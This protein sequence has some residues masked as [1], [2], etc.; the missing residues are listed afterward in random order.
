[1]KILITGADGMLGESLLTQLKEKGHRLFAFS[2]TRKTKELTPLEITNHAQV[3]HIITTIKPDSIVH[4]AALTNVDYCEQH[5]GKAYK[6]NFEATKHIVTVCKK[7]NIPLYFLSTGAVFSGEKKNPYVEDDSC[8]P[9]NVYGKTKLEA[10][11]AIRKLSQY[12][13]IRTGWLIGGGSK[14]TKF[15]SFI[16]SQLKNKKPL[17]RAVSD[18]Y[19]SPTLTFDLAKAVISLVERKARGTLHVVNRGVASRLDVA[20]KILDIF[21]PEAKLEPVPLGYFKEKARRPRMEALDPSKLKSKYHL[22]LPL[23]QISLRAYIR[24]LT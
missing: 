14:D 22:L 1:M 10:E 4:L 11:E 8:V 15:V 16:L 12:C 20:K 17:I 5:P 2:H 18:V 6:V 3:T 23:W 13:I 9:V 19:G 7:E 21:M 24:S